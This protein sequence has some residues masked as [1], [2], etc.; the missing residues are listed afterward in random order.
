VPFVQGHLRKEVQAF[1]VSTECAHCGRALHLEL[2]RDLNC[3]VVEKD[4]APLVFSPNVD[5]DK[6]EDP[7]IIDAY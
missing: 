7:S 2:D 3:R 5:F 1:V 4:A 6:L